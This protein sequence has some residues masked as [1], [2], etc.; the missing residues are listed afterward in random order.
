M[1]TLRLCSAGA[2]SGKTYSICEVV[3]GE[4]SQGRLDPARLVAT[5]YTRKAATELKARVEA[6]ILAAKGIAFDARLRAVERLDLALMGTVHSVG[7]QILSRYAVQLGLSPQLEV[8]TEDGERRHLEGFLSSISPELWLDLVEAAT[9]LGVPSP[10][11]VVLDLLGAKRLNR[12]A[13]ESFRQQLADS[14]EALIEVML[15]GLHPIEQDDPD[16]ELRRLA[17][18][19]LS[20]MPASDTTKVTREAK[21]TLKHLAGGATLGWND[22]ASAAKLEAGKKSGADGLLDDLRRAGG[23]VRRYR[24]LHDQVRA[25][26]RCLGEAVIGVEQSYQAYKAERGLVDFT[27]LETL[28][29][30]ALTN[31]DLADDLSSDIGLVVVDEFQDT[32]PIQLA[33]FERLLDLA[34]QVYWVGDEKQAIYGFRG[35]DP[36]LMREV[37]DRHDTAAPARLTK[38]WRS[39]PPI[40][41]LVNELFVPELGDGAHLEPTHDPEGI[42]LERWNMVGAKNQPQRAAC[43]AS[44]VA[45]LVAEGV[46]PGEI[47]VLVRRNYFASLVA[48]ALAEQGIPVSLGQPGLLSTREGAMVLAGL[49]LVADRRDSLAAATLLHVDSDPEADT[50]AWLAQRLE[51]VNAHRDAGPGAGAPVPWEDHRLLARLD[52]I[53]ARIL[54]PSAVTA[55]VIH[56]LGVDRRIGSWGDPLRRAG[57]LDALVAAAI[58]YE[59]EALSVGSTA[60]LSGL[61]TWLEKLAST[62]ADTRPAPSGLDAVCVST[63]HAAKGLEWPI[64]V[65]CEL[66]RTFDPRIFGVP[67]VTGGEP[68][69]GRP[70]E[71]RRLRYWPWPLGYTKDWRGELSPGPGCGLEEDALASETGAEEAKLEEEESLRVL[72]VALTR[73]RERLVL[74]YEQGGTDWLDRLSTVNEVLPDMDAGEHLLEAIDRMIQVRDV[75]PPQD[76][77]EP[78]AE[79]EATWHANPTPW[80][81]PLE[82]R[83]SWPSAAEAPGRVRTKPEPLPGAHPFGAIERPDDASAA[84]SAVHAFLAALPSLAETG[85]EERALVADRCLRAFNV[86]GFVQP[87]DLVGAGE[88]F[89]RWYEARFD[90]A[91]LATEVQFVAPRAERGRWVG[92]VDALLTLPDGGLVIVDHKSAR[93]PEAGWGAA[94]S[95]HAGQLRA[96]AEAFE[97]IG[98][99]VHS[100]WIHFP[101]GGGVVQVLAGT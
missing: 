58:E 26:Q 54:S 98:R 38:N 92:A 39:R 46:P 10:G 1:S 56:A 72:Y 66:D 88:R 41:E 99:T 5:T 48:R 13:D 28:L 53:D 9:P 19:A 27:D 43:V 30:D 3:V 25:Y 52:A 78:D 81:H 96:Y 95:E 69:A 2:G 34:E 87:E 77:P 65:V 36:R 85:P 70:L 17:G 97:S 37:W 60:T 90:G 62:E 67:R 49:R 45:E 73:A 14:A 33:I 79:S 42:S 21:T 50:P 91:T 55:A 86:G 20:S 100:A 51:Q 76:L 44:G 84:G 11:K 83:D 101:L 18:D 68:E 40:V 64:V 24:V 32:N 89:V 6:G 31:E 22:H 59:T 71:G 47:A 75:N 12:I 7:Q 57:H 29:L 15:C 94:A 74:A 82:P 63:C 80:T 61:I 35:A 93:V 4:I 16:A 23:R 8:L